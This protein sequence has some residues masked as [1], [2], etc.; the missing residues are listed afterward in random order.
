MHQ[1]GK[2][3]STLGMPGQSVMIIWNILTLQERKHFHK[4]P[5]EECMDVGVGMQQLDT[6]QGTSESKVNTLQYYREKR[7]SSHNAV[8]FVTGRK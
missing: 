7:N 6:S 8:S 3:P 1:G 5:I 4:F 2:N